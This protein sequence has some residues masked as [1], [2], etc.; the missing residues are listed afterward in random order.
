M[1]G[2]YIKPHTLWVMLLF[3]AN[4]LKLTDISSEVK[5][6][7]NWQTFGSSTHVASR[8]RYPYGERTFQSRFLLRESRIERKTGGELTRKIM[9]FDQENQYHISVSVKGIEKISNTH[10]HNTHTRNTNFAGAPS[11]PSSQFVPSWGE[12]I[13][14]LLR[15]ITSCTI[16]VDPVGYKLQLASH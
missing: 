12:G 1:G 15:A 16:H 14:R 9:T 13:M 4:F 11:L 2:N 3:L 8:S 5:L 10:T 6:R 7:G